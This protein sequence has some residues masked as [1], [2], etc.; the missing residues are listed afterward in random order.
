[1]S[2]IAY[3]RRAVAERNPTPQTRLVDAS[4]VEA[5]GGFGSKREAI[6]TPGNGY[7]PIWLSVCSSAARSVSENLLMRVS[8]TTRAW[9]TRARSMSAVPDS[10]RQTA[11]PR[12]SSSAS[13]RASSLAV[14]VPSCTQLYA[15]L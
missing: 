7:W 8:C 11:T 4:T 2:E 3:H 10:V 13:Q 15:R 5:G 12:A 1:M 9:M 14:M 6:S